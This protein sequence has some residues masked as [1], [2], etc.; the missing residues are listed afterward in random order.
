[1]LSGDD[2]LIGVA[3]RLADGATPET[4]RVVKQRK[5]SR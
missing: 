2:V 4:A 5:G 1:M 3:E